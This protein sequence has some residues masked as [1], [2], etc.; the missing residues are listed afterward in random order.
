MRILDHLVLAFNLNIFLKKK[1]ISI[2]TKSFLVFLQY[3]LLLYFYKW[4]NKK[5]IPLILDVKDKWP[6]TFIDPSHF[7]LKPGSKI[8]IRTIFFDNQI[9]IYKI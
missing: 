8:F 4:A 2:Q 6:E 1:K 9:C 3:L 5:N 7:L